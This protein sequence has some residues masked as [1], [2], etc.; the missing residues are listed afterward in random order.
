MYHLQHI[1]LLQV[2]CLETEPIHL[3]AIVD[4]VRMPVRRE[5]VDLVS[6]FFRWSGYYPILGPFQDD[7]RRS[8]AIRVHVERANRSLPSNYCPVQLALQWWDMEFGFILRRK[9][10]LRHLV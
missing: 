4:V 8:K 5:R 3:L 6:V 10:R 9:T 1:P 7:Y 2:D